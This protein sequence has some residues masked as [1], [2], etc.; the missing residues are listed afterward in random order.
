MELLEHVLKPLELQMSFS[1]N[2]TYQ[3]TQV[4][5]DVE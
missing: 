4:Q 1:M 2:N 5:T 3:F